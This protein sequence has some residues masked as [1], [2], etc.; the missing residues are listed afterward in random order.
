MSL[1]HRLFV[2]LQS[3]FLSIRRSV[4]IYR[5]LFILVHLGSS[6]F[7]CK[8]SE[9]YVFFLFLSFDFLRASSVLIKLKEQLSDLKEKEK[10]PE[11]VFPDMRFSCQATSVRLTEWEEVDNFDYDLTSHHVEKERVSHGR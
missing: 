4:P 5:K 8:L 6:Q 3:A 11:L 9:S 2:F 10:E 1:I 7:F